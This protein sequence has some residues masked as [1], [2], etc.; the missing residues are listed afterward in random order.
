LRG[1]VAYLVQAELCGDGRRNEVGVG[2]RCQRH[3][4]NTIVE[5]RPLLGGE[6][7]GEP[8]LSG[9]AGAREGEQTNLLAHQELSRC[10]ELLLAADERGTG[11]GKSARRCRWCR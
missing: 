4:D 8:G 3:E 5:A 9:A 2:K 7:E 6:G 11:H 10:N 1:L